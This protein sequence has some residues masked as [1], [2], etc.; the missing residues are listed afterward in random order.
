MKRATTVM[1]GILAVA[2][3]AACG[4][5]TTA[6][7]GQV[8]KEGS[9]T[10]PAGLQP[11]AGS[12]A[13][14]AP[15]MSSAAVPSPVGA[16]P[17]GLLVQRSG[18][19]SIQVARGGFDRGLDRILDVMQAEHGFVSG[20]SSATPLGGGDRIGIVTF[21]V[22]ADRF[23][24][25]LAQLRGIGETRDL[26][27]S[28]N[29]VSTQ[30][31]DVQSRL[32][33]AEAQRDAYLAILAQAR[34]VSEVVLVQDRLGSVTSQIEQLRG[35]LNYLDH[36]TTYATIT[37]TLRE[38]PAVPAQ[39]DSWGFRAALWQSLH[40]FVGSVNGLAV[41]LGASAPFLLLGG[42]LAALVWRLRRPRAG[43]TPAAG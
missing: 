39:P 17:A 16:L 26:A 24:D 37:A 38:L 6:W 19:I 33:A 1:L 35:Q 13:G 27:V 36:T 12:T 4:A 31:I 28:G 34:T 18:R 2:V 41:A 30:Y 21:Q 15:A 10:A 23:V 32:R 14:A 11:G 29:D 5:G 25:T 42:L 22:P 3:L 8:P 7:P 20:N 43:G 40:A 9:A